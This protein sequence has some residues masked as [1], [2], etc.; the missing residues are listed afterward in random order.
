MLTDSRWFSV[1]TL[2]FIHNYLCTHFGSP[3]QQGVREAVRNCSLLWYS[4]PTACPTCLWQW[5]HKWVEVYLFWKNFKKFAAA[6]FKE[7]GEGDWPFC[8]QRGG[9]YLRMIDVMWATAMLW[10]SLAAKPPRSRGGEREMSAGKCVW[11]YSLYL[12]AN[13]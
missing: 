9:R 1:V 2:F 12:T 7:G 8:Q 5:W 13:K 11:L 4:H 3:G 10:S 6:S